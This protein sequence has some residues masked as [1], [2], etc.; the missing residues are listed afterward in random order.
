MSIAMFIVFLPHT[1]GSATK[2]INPID[3]FFAHDMGMAIVQ[4]VTI[5]AHKYR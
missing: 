5:T 2:H 4:T 3:V 1:F